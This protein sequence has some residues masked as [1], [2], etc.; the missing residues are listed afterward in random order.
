MAYYLYRRRRKGKAQKKGEE[1]GSEDSW[2]SPSSSP[3]NIHKEGNTFAARAMRAE[4]A[5]QERKEKGEKQEGW[6]QRWP[7]EK[8]IAHYA[9]DLDEGS[10]D[11]GRYDEIA[12]LQKERLYQLRTQNHSPPP[13]PN[14]WKPSQTLAVPEGSS[15]PP[16][17][18]QTTG[19]VNAIASGAGKPSSPRSQR[20]PD[21]QV[22][23]NEFISTPP[24]PS[25]N[26]STIPQAITKLASILKQPPTEPKTLLAKAQSLFNSASEYK[27]TFA[28]PKPQV[29]KKGVTF[30]EDQVREFGLT[31]VGSCVWSSDDTYEEVDL[32][33]TEARDTRPQGGKRRESGLGHDVEGEVWKNEARSN[34][35]RR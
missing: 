10:S 1:I 5:A 23:H 14:D 7:Q 35:R 24:P 17:P 8:S 31:P 11:G 2:I 25:P 30:G 18:R 27:P 20:S 16:L 3:T 26:D 34:S 9:L 19:E 32:R 29:Q 22:S 33:E 12:S 15:L 28:E 6:S 13:H 4:M 21:V